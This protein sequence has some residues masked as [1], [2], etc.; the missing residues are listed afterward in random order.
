ME[1]HP[2][3]TRKAMSRSVVTFLLFTACCMAVHASD[4]PVRVFMAGDSTMAIKDP[5]DYPETGWGLPFASFFG[6][7]VE[8][9]NYAENGRS[10]RTFLEAGLWQQIADSLEPGDYVFIQFGHNDESVQKADR[11]TTPD[12]FRANLTLFISEARAKGAD[13]T[14]LSPVTRRH[15]SEH[16]RIA[17][18]HPYSPL[19]IEVAKATG[20]EFIDLDAITREY[21]ES[22]GDRESAVRFMHIPPDTHPNYPRGVRDDT[23]TNELGAREIAQLVLAELKQRKHPLAS[24]LRIPDPKHLELEYR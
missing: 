16:G 1:I 2:G 11:Y 8:V 18:T 4:N 20:V 12:Q 7:T 23:H 24:R 14:L 10:T 5:K 15:F 17:E 3:G 13:P 9:R 19:S 22:M 21:F 6:E